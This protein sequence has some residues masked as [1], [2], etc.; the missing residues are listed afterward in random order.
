MKVSTSRRAHANECALM[1]LPPGSLSPGPPF[2]HSPRDPPEPAGRSGPVFYQITAF[3]L[4]PGMCE[5][6]CTPFKGEVSISLS[7]DALLCSS[8]VGLQNQVLFMVLEPWARRPTW[9]SELSLLYV[10]MC[11]IFILH[12]VGCVPGEVWNSII[13]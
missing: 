7:L 1:F 3:A 10:K 2:P 6:L 4:G 5:I 12:F 13:L 9:D 8:P 11:N